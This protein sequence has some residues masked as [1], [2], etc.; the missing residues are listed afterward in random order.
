MDEVFELGEDLLD[1]VEIGGIWQRK[2]AMSAGID[3]RSAYGLAF[4]GSKIVHDDDVAGRKRR[5]EKLLDIGKEAGAIDR[6]V[7]HAGRVD[8]VDAQG[9]KKRQRAPT[10]MRCTIN[11]T[12]TARC[13]ASQRC[14][15]R[16]RPGLVDEDETCRVHARLM[17]DPPC[18]PT[19]NIRPVLLCCDYGFFVAQSFAMDKAPH[20]AP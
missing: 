5:H 19:G 4:V 15:I 9:G 18:P 17:L 12:F 14:H 7:K 11:Q 1:W 16:F 8:P 2:E 13:P 20:T 3:D 10:S 6:A